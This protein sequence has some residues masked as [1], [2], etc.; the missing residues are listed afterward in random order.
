MDTHPVIPTLIKL[1]RSMPRKRHQNG[2]VKKTGKKPR[3][4]TGYWYIYAPDANGKEKRYERSKVLGPSADLTKAQAEELLRRHIGNYRPTAEGIFADA[5]KHYLKM[6]QGDWGK[7]QRGVVAS[8]FKNQILPG[9]GSKRIADIKPSDIKA[10]FND[11]AANPKTGSESLIKKCITHTRGVFELLVEDDL[12][13]KNP[14][15]SKM[16]TKP[17]TR[18]PSERFL[19]LSECTQLFR[20][21]DGRDYIILRILLSCALRP[22]ELF[23]LRV[24]DVLPGKLRIDEGAVPGQHVKDET[25]TEDSDG[26]VPISS[27]LEMEIRTYM[28]DAKLFDA[29]QFLFPSQVGSAMSHD[30]YLDRVLKRIATAANVKHVNFQVLRRTVATHMQDHGEAKSAQG[31]LRHSDP[32]T[33]LKHYQKRLDASVVKAAESWDAALLAR[34]QNHLQ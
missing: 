14:A 32:H 12:I 11:L 20:A 16:V 29:R 33:T 5:A 21:A 24:D 7:K 25:K 6:K 9:L 30:N 3:T 17:K 22:S 27:T 1:G 13:R 8:I 31:L 4:W 23:A 15:R 28:R 10:F 19:D 18:K 26:F 2:F 34:T